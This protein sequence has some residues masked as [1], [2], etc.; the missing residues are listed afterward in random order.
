MEPDPDRFLAELQTR[1]RGANTLQYRSAALLAHSGE[2][3][4]HVAIS[5]T[6]RRPNLGRIRF[7]T[8]EV[9][10]AARVRVGDGR[11]LYDRQQ[12]EV[13]KAG[14]TRWLAY[15]NRLTDDLTHPL[16]EV[17]YF[18]DQFFSPTP[19]LPKPFWGTGPLAQDLK[20]VPIDEPIRIVTEVME[21][22]SKR[23]DAVVKTW[24]RKVLCFSFSAGASS[25]TFYFD[26]ITYAPLALIR[27]GDHAGRIQ[28]LLREVFIQF[29]LGTLSG[30]ANPFVWTDDDERGIVKPEGR[31]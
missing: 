29:S 19:F 23:I 20:T 14:R 31:R 7:D 5:A 26:P 9:P 21:K 25:D 30:L 12:G 1:W 22:D 10:E 11:R 8:T 16:D 15:N 17:A 3:R 24:P 27:V 18:P 4:L 2:F 6:F 13:G 28:E